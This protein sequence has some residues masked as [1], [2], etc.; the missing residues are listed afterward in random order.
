MDFRVV[1]GGPQSLNRFNAE[2]SSKSFFK[3]KSKSKKLQRLAL[4]FVRPEGGEKVRPEAEGFSCYFL[5]SFAN[6]KLTH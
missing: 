4:L 2:I 6:L 1:Y 5:Y 3:K